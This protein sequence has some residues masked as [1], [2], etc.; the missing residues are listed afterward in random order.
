MTGMAEDY[1]ALKLGASAVGIEM[2]ELPRIAQE[3]FEEVRDAVGP[4][5]QSVGAG[6]M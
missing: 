5:L 4:A 2:G 1:L 6:S 3:S